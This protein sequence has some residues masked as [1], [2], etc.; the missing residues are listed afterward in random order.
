MFRS[1]FTT[2]FS[3]LGGLLVYSFSRIYNYGLTVQRAELPGLTAPLRVAQLSDL[4]FGH[5]IGPEMVR[6]WSDTA[7]AARPDVIVITGDFL[8][9]RAGVRQQDQLLE[10]LARLAAPLG[11]Y[12]VYGNHDWTSLGSGAARAGYAR[13]LESLY[14]H[15]INNQGRRPLPGRSGRLV[16]RGAGRGGDAGEAQ[17]R[18][19]PAACL[20]PG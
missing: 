8:D 20:Q 1:R 14:I 19:G 13:R 7:V 3:L 6:R 16:V 9:S 2:A 11:V 17:G 18:R 10:E 12:A 15:V 4:H 5:F